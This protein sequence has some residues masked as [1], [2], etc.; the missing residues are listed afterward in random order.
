MNSCK[1]IRRSARGVLPYLLLP[2]MLAGQNR[3]NITAPE[4]N[5]PNQGVRITPSAVPGG[6]FQTLNPGLKEFPN[7]VAGGAVTTVVSPDKK[8]LLVL[9]SGFNRMND[10]AGKEIPQ[11]STQYVFVFDISEKKPVQ[12]QTIHVPNTYSGIAFDPTGKAF[13]VSG[14]VDDN[15]HIYDLRPNGWAESADSPVPLGHNGEGVGL[16]VKPQAAGIAVTADG[17]QIVVTNYYNDSISVLTKGPEGRW[18]KTGELD[19]RPGKID[20]AQS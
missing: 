3:I 16:D 20:P 5:I 13:Y 6:S 11:D 17:E 9:T 7:Y 2:A 19:L 12:R 4:M 8:T 10:D 14:G 15:V 18:A 1:W